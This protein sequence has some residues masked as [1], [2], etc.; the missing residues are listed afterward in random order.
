MA[1]ITVL[2]KVAAD[3][4]T[5]RRL[6]DNYFNRYGYEVLAPILSPEECRKIIKTFDAHRRDTSYRIDDA[7][8][9]V[10][11]SDGRSGLDLHVSQLM[12][13]QG[14]SDIL[15]TLFTSGRI[16]SVFNSRLKRPIRL[17][18]LTIQED[19][20]DTSTKRGFH[21]DHLTPPTYKMFVYLTDVPTLAHGPYTVIPGSHRDILG[22]LV[23][24]VGNRMRGRRATDMGLWYSL[25]RAV[26]ILGT[27]GATI[28]SCQT[29]AHR[30]WPRQTAA[31]RVMLVAYLD[32]KTEDTNTFRLGANLVSLAT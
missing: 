20:P 2:R 24:V 12:N 13:A 5:W 8:Y 25:R 30:G 15:F 11:R 1:K 7:A 10:K 27:A 19:Q 21:V 26:P 6:P 23:N 22:K 28:I 4:Q 14:I 32:G 9:F 29:I 17:R 3:L 16:E 31:R 18:S